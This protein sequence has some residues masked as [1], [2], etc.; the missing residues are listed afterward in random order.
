MVTTGERQMTALNSARNRGTRIFT[1]DLENNV[2]V[3][4]SKNPASSAAGLMK[5]ESEQDLAA[6][7]ANWP[8]SRLV[9][10]WN[11]LPGAQRLGRFTDRKTAVRRIWKAVVGGERGGKEDEATRGGT[12]PS[13]GNVAVK[14]KSLGPSS[15]KAEQILALLRRP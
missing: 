2:G 8:S 11:K 9:E 13:R 14:A 7:V 1:I 10:V 3:H 6:L 12:S 15:T 4:A 5:F